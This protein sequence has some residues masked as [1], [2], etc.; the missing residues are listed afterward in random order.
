MARNGKTIYGA[1]RCEVRGSMFANFTR[2]GKTLYVHVHHWPGE[3]WA[4][5][6]LRATV[7]S[8]KLLSTGRRVRF[9][10]DRFR[11]QFSGLPARAPD[12][13]VTVLALECASVPRQDMAA[14]RTGRKREG[15]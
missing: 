6:G 1:E 15:V 5:G 8:A 11:V 14:V 3:S 9:E 10:Q 13:P 7:K 4:I 2:K 12:S